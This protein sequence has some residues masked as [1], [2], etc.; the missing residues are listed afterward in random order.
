MDSR[1]IR[2]D[3]R[4]AFLT[5]K[6]RSLHASRYFPKMRDT[7]S[8][9]SLGSALN[10]WRQLI[11]DQHARTGLPIELAERC[12]RFYFFSPAVVFNQKKLEILHAVGLDESLLVEMSY[13]AA[14]KKSQREVW[15]EIY[16]K[17]AAQILMQNVQGVAIPVLIRG[18]EEYAQQCALSIAHPGDWASFGQDWLQFEDLTRQNGDPAAFR[19][20]TELRGIIKDTNC[21][22]VIVTHMATDNPPRQGVTMASMSWSLGTHSRQV[23]QVE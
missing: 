17:A 19:T 10:T 8:L 1:E 15:Q 14:D 21:R 2:T 3:H 12:Q 23:I 5:I 18:Y 11:T 6:G 4:I 16:A 22:L 20:L 7:V 9:N 13:K